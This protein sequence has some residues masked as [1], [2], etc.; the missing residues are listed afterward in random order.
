MRRVERINSGEETAD[1]A[2][3]FCPISNY[4]IIT[5]LQTLSF[6]SLSILW[7]YYPFI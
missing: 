7:V 2:M 1:L 5:I 6:L 4:Y 3:H